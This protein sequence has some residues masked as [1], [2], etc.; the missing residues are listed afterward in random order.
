MYRRLLEFVRPYR[1]RMF[2]AIVCMTVTAAINASIAYMVKPVLDDIFVFKDWQMLKILPFLLL[3]LFFLKSTFTYI[4]HYLMW[5]I[6]EQTVKNLRNDLFA[7]VHSLS[8]DFF[9]KRSTGMIMARITHDV[10]LIQKAVTQALADLFHE[11]LNVIGYMGVM[12]YCNW[13]WAFLALGVLPLVVFLIYGLGLK[14][15]KIVKKVQQK[16]ADLNVILHETI[17]GALI[18]KAFATEEQEVKKY[19]KENQH[20]F[21]QEMRVGRIMILTPPLMEFIGSIGIAFVVW[22]GGAQVIA[23]KSTP[24][25]FFSF[26]T[27]LLMMYGP[28]KK[29]A[30]VNNL[31]QKGIAATQRIFEF[32]DIHP[33]VK[34][35]E[36]AVAMPLFQKSIEFQKVSFKYEEELVLDK[37]NL[38]V[39]K[40]EIVAIVGGSGAGKTTLVNLLLRFYEPNSGCIVIDGQ[41]IRDFTLASLRRQIGIVTQETILFNDTIKN[42]LIYGTPQAQEEEILSAAQAALADEFIKKMPQGFDTII[43]ERGT[44]LSGGQRQR[45][46]IA[47]AILKNPPIMVLDEATSALDSKSEVLVQRAME[48]LMKNRTTFIIAHRLSTIRKAHKIIV[49]HQGEIQELGTHDALLAKN[50]I[51]AHL[52]HLQFADQAES[53][54]RPTS[55]V[56][57]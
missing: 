4:Q 17:S 30:N 7:H 12:F 46:A 32:F 49:L 14:L 8:M 2:I 54:A 53:V 41:D 6:G 38:Q 27:A 45:V 13:R 10:T 48:N 47:R 42:N 1:K 24:G 55:Q 56:G 31:T 29:L 25:N 26:L 37:I 20:Y 50:G 36:D 52:Y 16:M 57:D 11:P 5:Y 34:E 15:R 19:Q 39:A 40:G 43:G 9:T 21:N 22:F 35:K 18:V 51:Y 3:I 23:G 28:L 44:K 33:T